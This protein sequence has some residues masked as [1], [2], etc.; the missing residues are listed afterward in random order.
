MKDGVCSPEDVDTAMVE[1]LAPRYSFMGIFETMHLNADGNQLDSC[2]VS[3]SY[4]RVPVSFLV[5]NN[6]CRGIREFS[7][8]PLHFRNEGLL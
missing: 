8:R 4:E 3:I 1:G 6:G 5:M 2:T 7:K